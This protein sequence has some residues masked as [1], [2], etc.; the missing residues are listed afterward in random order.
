MGALLAAGCDLPPGPPAE[1]DLLGTVLLD[2][3]VD[4]SPPDGASLD[5]NHL[6]LDGGAAVLGHLFITVIDRDT[7]LPTPARVVVRPIP[8]A[9]YADNILGGTLNLDSMGSRFAAVVGPGVLGSVEGV[10]LMNGTGV[11]PIPAGTWTLFVNRG[12]EYEGVEV[13][14]TIGAG[15]V[16]PITVNLDHSVDTRGWLSADLHVHTVRSF[17]ARLSLERRVISMVTNQVDV[18]VTADHNVSTDLKPTIA[19]L[20]YDDKTVGTVIGDEFNF[21]EGHGGAYPMPYNPNDLMGGGAP[22]YQNLNPNTGKC[23]VPMIGINCYTAAQAFP[24]MRAQIPGTTVVT[25]NHPWYPPGNDLGYFTNIGWGAGA[26]S[27]LPATMPTAGTF[28]AIEVVGGYWSRPDVLGY[29]TADWFYLLGQG[30]KVT[31]LGSSDTHKINWVR[32]GWPRTWFRLPTD[33]PGEVT[34]NMIAEAVKKQRAIAST[35]PFV[36][37]TVDGAQIG[38]TVVPKTAGQVTVDITVDAPAWMSVDTVK[39][40][41]SGK[42]ERTIMVPPG[43]RPV[44]T[45]SVVQTLAGDGWVV[46]NVTGSKPLPPDVVGEYSIN[47]GWNVL[48]WAITNPVFVDGNNDGVVNPPPAPFPPGGLKKPQPPRDRLRVPVDCEPLQKMPS[49]QPEPIEP[50]TRILMPLLDF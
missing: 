34:G 7:M 8:G 10:M 17:D 31:A 48:P 43:A 24:M 14:V 44:Y 30:Y 41:V 16:Q 13:P 28:D 22:I 3:G 50:A 47:N 32:S 20:G 23:D 45:G 18:I 6:P 21:N 37:I 46:V 35:G 15:Q 2:G 9:G 38:D 19:N 29:L 33:K 49:A 11:V 39:V 40:Y 36:T 12:P 25:V 42:L 5:G 26:T 27:G 4:F 1:A